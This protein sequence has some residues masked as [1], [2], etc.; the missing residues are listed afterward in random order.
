MHN[1]HQAGRWIV[2]VAALAGATAL[3]LSA[4]SAHAL[5]AWIG[6][7][8]LARLATANRYLMYYSLVLLVIGLFYP[9]R[10][11]SGLLTVAKLFTTGVG[12]F[13]G[14]LYILCFTE[15]SWIARLTPLGGLTLLAGWLLLA[16]TGW[17]QGRDK[18]D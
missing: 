11:W 18:D 5:K 8:D 3:V 15:I 16:W 4:S 9:L 17:R 12:I 7:D 10:P 13:C 2:V 14:S 1:S 6:P